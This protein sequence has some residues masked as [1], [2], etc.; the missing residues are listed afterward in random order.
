MDNN[1][2]ED[3]PNA[4]PAIQVIEQS[5]A[6]EASGAGT[7]YQNQSHFQAEINE[8][9]LTAAPARSSSYFEW[10]ITAD[11]MEIDG[12]RE[13]CGEDHVEDAEEI[14]EPESMNNDDEGNGDHI[15]NPEESE[16]DMDEGDTHPSLLPPTPLKGYEYS[17][18]NPTPINPNSPGT[19]AYMPP[20]TQADVL[21]AMEDLKKILHPKHDTR[22]GYKDPKIDLWRRARVEGMLSMFYMF[23]NWESHTY[24]HWGAS[25]C[26]A[27]I[28]MGR[29]KHCA[30]RLCELNR[31][32]LA[33]R[34][35]LP[36][37]PY[38]D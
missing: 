25:A 20:P 2:D 35:I 29:G 23:T 22:R 21:V 4:H 14:D 7:F 18:F 32:F 1:S 5:D 28:G 33:D 8:G 16:R 17:T 13:D 9:V 12:G 15:D 6:A 10:H 26:Q 36:V 34:S 27:A 37:N 11:P 31:G 3:I 24:N 38:G 19:T 30:R